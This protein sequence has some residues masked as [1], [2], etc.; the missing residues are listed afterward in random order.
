MDIVDELKR[1]TLEHYGFRER[2]DLDI[3]A[4]ENEAAFCRRE[5]VRWRAAEEIERL[6][7][8]VVARGDMEAV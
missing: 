3:P 5:D 2:R 7:R 1:E 6:R 4:D 8:E